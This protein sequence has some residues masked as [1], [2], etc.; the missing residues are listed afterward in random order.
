MSSTARATRDVIRRKRKKKR[1][2]LP[3]ARARARER[4]D[5]ASSYARDSVW[6]TTEERICAVPA[7]AFVPVLTRHGATVDH[8]FP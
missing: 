8:P 4:D 7:Q 3:A 1:K 6:A 5:P 2:R